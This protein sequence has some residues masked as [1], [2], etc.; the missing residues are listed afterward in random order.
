MLQLNTRIFSVIL[1]SDVTSDRIISNYK[2][3]RKV[4]SFAPLRITFF[5]LEHSLQNINS[6]YNVTWYYRHRMAEAG[7]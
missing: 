3:F 4:G 7:I 2:I 5:P 1:S 6:Y